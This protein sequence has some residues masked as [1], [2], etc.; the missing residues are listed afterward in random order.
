MLPLPMKRC[1]VFL[2]ILSVSLPLA[3]AQEAE[4]EA[5]ENG[6]TEPEAPA[7]PEYAWT[8]SRPAGLVT[9]PFDLTLN[10]DPN[11]R[12]IRFTTDGSLPTGESAEWLDRLQVT[13]TSQLRFAVLDD[14]GEALS[15]F[16]LAYVFIDPDLKDTF[17]SNLPVVIVHTFGENLDYNDQQNSRSP[18][19]P[20]WSVFY[21][22]SREAND[23]GQRTT[24]TESPHFSGRAGMRVRGQT[25]TMF[26]KKQYTFELWDGEDDDFDASL[27]GMPEESDWILHAPYSDKTLMRNVLAYSLFREMG[28]Y[29]V[30]TQYVELFANMTGGVVTSRDYRGVY[31]FM[32]KIKRDK[33]RLP[34]TKLKETDSAEPEITGGYI[35]KKDKGTYEDVHF[36]TWGGHQFGFVEPDEPTEAQFDYL[37]N[38]VHAFEQALY[39]RGFDAPEGGYRDFIDVSSFIDVHIHVELCRNIDGFRL[40][41]YFHKD[42]EGK[43]TMGPVWD[44]NL[45]LGN[46]TM[47]GGWAPQGWYHDTIRRREYT[48]FDRLFDDPA[49]EL[50]HWDRYYELRQSVLATDK[51]MHQIDAFAAEL[52]ESQQRNFDRWPIL[53]YRVW[54]NPDG[55]HTRR[56]HR[57]EVDWMKRWLQQ[58]LDWLDQQFIPPPM[59]GLEGEDAIAHGT[60]VALSMPAFHRSTQQP[61]LY[62][63]LGGSDPRAANGQPTDVARGLRPGEKAILDGAGPLKVRAFDGQRWGALSLTAYSIDPSLVKPSPPIPTGIPRPNLPG[64][65]LT[66]GLLMVI[67]AGTIWRR[68][69]M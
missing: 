37:S 22:G 34:I 14:E 1:A 18:K 13:E 19:R 40:S 28:H 30:K 39:S 23:E 66:L 10:V 11:D 33:K 59:V 29:A 67:F 58:R 5:L 56:T 4:P 47:R 35:F 15:R 26:P 24:L 17:S 36:D 7:V 31:V 65:V 3:S 48:Y 42:R 2:L 63:T 57:A 54:Q 6:I 55:F 62:Y 49:F 61:R 46:T 53:G 32:E 8:P 27:L 16:D 20:V 50:A 45:S 52:E 9:T 68:L 12:P 38:H 64:W 25:S 43:I 69:R 21:D 51:L 41:T 60:E 44:Y